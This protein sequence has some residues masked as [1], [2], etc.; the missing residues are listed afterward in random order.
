M[1]TWKVSEFIKA[2]S[3][4]VIKH[5]SQG[6]FISRDLQA[7]HEQHYVESC[8]KNLSQRA[9]Q[10]HWRNP[11]LL[12]N[13]MAAK[14]FHI[15][16]AVVLAGL[17]FLS[18]TRNTLANSKI[19]AFIYSLQWTERETFQGVAVTLENLRII[20]F[21]S[22]GQCDCSVCGSSCNGSVS[23]DPGKFAVVNGSDFRGCLECQAGHL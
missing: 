6:H 21:L 14:T 22:V 3:L 12:W 4:P 1:T 10:T 20:I 8:M 16:L 18:W 15:R 17:T 19:N 7:H 2:S 5:C 13:C 23:C 9:K 11:Y